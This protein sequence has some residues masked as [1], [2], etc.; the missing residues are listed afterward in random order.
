[1]SAVQVKICGLTCAEDALAAAELGADALGFNLIPSSRRYCAPARIREILRLLPASVAAIGVLRDSPLDEAR[2]ALDEAGLQL[3]QLH[4][5]ES[6]G[7][8]EALG[9]PVIKA[10][11]IG[12]AADL[13]RALGHAR[14]GA[15]RGLLLDAPSAEGGGAGRVFDWSLAAG[16][17]APVPIWIA[18]GL[19]AARVGRAVARLRPHGVDVASGVEREP[20]QKDREKMAQFIRAAKEIAC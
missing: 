20:G 18:G 9:M 12:S 13:T 5:G 10:I 19:D 8:V 14:G 6:Q 15:V 2:R 4:G 3:A 1:M 17:V 11:S 16:F 7:Y